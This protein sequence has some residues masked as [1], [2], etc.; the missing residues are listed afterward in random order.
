MNLRQ[1]EVF[2][3]LQEALKLDWRVVYLVDLGCV[4]IYIYMIYHIT[5]MFYVFLY[6]LIQAYI[7]KLFARL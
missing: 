7:G 3:R 4:Y 6:Y 5:Y 2:A 1:E